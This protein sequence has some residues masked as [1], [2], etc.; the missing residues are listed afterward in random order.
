MVVE[1]KTEVEF[2]KRVLVPALSHGGVAAT[3]VSM[4]GN[5]TRDRVAREVASLFR[6]FDCVTSFVDFYGFRD[7]GDLNVEQLEQEVEQAA[8]S[9]IGRRYDASRVVVYVQRHE[10]EGL[11]FSDVDGFA[12]RDWRW[13]KAVWPDCAGCDSGFRRP[14]TSTTTARRRRASGFS[15]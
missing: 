9:R 3:P 5:V 7:K 14:R 8:Q 2:V 15:R 1:G 11:L 12:T 13:T 4:D 6:S 10:F